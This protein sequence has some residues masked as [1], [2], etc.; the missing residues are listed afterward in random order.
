MSSGIICCCKTHAQD[1]S[2]LNHVLTRC[3]QNQIFNSRPTPSAEHLVLI[4]G[5]DYRVDCAIWGEKTPLFHNSVWCGELIP[6]F[7]LTANTHGHS[8]Q[9]RLLA[10]HGRCERQW[11]SCASATLMLVTSHSL[12]Y[13]CEIV[14]A[15]LWWRLCV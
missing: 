3:P 1:C 15:C 2:L 14:T 13:F 6:R 11:S 7:C 10:V 9:C 12:F 4:P 8:V 5:M